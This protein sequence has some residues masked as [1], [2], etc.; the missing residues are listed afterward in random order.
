MKFSGTA[1]EYLDTLI[2]VRSNNIDYNDLFVYFL[3]QGFMLSEEEVHDLMEEQG[4][5]AI[6]AYKSSMSDFLQIEFEEESE[7]YVDAAIKEVK[8]DEFLSNPYVKA[9]NISSVK[10]GKYTLCKDKYLPYEIFPRDDINVLDDYIEQPQI[11][12]FTKPFSF[13]ALREKNV[14]WMSLNPNEIN[15]MKKAI[16]NAS[17]NVLVLGL[18]LGY[19]PF[20][21]SLKDDVKEITI[22]EKDKDIIT[23]FKENILPN[24]KHKEKI[25]I[26]QDDAMKYIK[27]LENKASFDYLFADLWHNQEDGLPL[28]IDLLKEAR[29]LNLRSDYWLET[30]L[31]CY[32]RRMMVFDMW[33]IEYEHQPEAD[34]IK[35]INPIDRYINNIYFVIKDKEFST[36]E[37]LK[38]YL[39]DQSIK[40][41]LINEKIQVILIRL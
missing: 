27:K 2:N 5:T 36:K 31:I 8:P 7:I 39:S 30:S 12:Y 37:E 11:G 34:F 18:G 28:Y 14:T 21:I 10:L 15:T 23:L 29:R 24:F 38:N 16:D 26:I 41:L 17:G 40:E 13:L 9:I 4:L 3:E 25:K 1:K 20:M 19:Y 6:D 32:I 33:L 35:V 22:I